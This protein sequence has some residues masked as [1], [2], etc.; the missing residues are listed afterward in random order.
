M[1]VFK[2][3]QIRDA[4]N[5]HVDLPLIRISQPFPCC[6]LQPLALRLTF[7]LGVQTAGCLGPQNQTAFV[8]SIRAQADSS[9]SSGPPGFNADNKL[10]A[11]PEDIL[12]PCG[13]S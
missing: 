4:I 6:H 2:W 5:I 8:F 13:N 11:G 1:C 10:R 3:V 7:D 9:K 12:S